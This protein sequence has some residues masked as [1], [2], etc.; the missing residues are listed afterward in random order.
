MI[1]KFSGRGDGLVIDYR[2][3]PEALTTSVQFQQ[4][5]YENSPCFKGTT[6]SNPVWYPF[7]F[8]KGVAYRLPQHPLPNSHGRFPICNLC[9]KQINCLGGS[10]YETIDLV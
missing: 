1:E 2:P 3:Y 5:A 4:L 7:I 9:T 6:S 10:E 8:Y